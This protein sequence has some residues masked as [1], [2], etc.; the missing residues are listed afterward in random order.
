M[1]EEKQPSKRFAR[2]VT[3]LLEGASK[4]EMRS[5]G[6]QEV[7]DVMSKLSTDVRRE[8]AAQTLANI[9]TPSEPEPSIWLQ[10]LAN[11]N[12]PPEFE[13]PKFTRGGGNLTS[14]K[15]SF[16][17]ALNWANE[18]EKEAADLEKKAELLPV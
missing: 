12:A 4:L 2:V 7:M 18:Y 3:H 8:K 9:L 6:I 11:G 14:V 5:P 16:L 17:R 15:R 1:D 13:V 10:W